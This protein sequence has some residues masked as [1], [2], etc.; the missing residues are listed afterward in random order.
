[1]FKICHSAKR[2]REEMRERDD[3]ESHFE[4]SFFSQERCLLLTFISHHFN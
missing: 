1:M 2:E 3:Y 4:N